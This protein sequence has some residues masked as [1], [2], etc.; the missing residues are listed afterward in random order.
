MASR[1]SRKSR[2][3]SISFCRRTVKRATGTA[4]EANTIKMAHA[5]IS[6]RSVMPVCADCARATDRLRR[7]NGWISRMVLAPLGL[8]YLN[9]GFG[10]D[11][12]CRPL[13]GIA[14]VHLQNGQLRRAGLDS[15]NDNP[16]QSAAAADAGRVGH[17]CR[18]NN[19]L[20][21]LLIDAL[22]DGN[23]LRARCQEPSLADIFD[24]NHR[25]VELQQ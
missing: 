5:R 3:N 19:R 10:A 13:L 14:R 24:R 11:E 20:A 17:A 25:G 18:R 12:L 9:S 15:A 1:I 16:E 6:S 23:G 22:D 2:C 4:E 8:L 21:A 7:K